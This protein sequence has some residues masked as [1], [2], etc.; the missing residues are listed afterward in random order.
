MTVIAQADH[1][2][3]GAWVACASGVFIALGNAYKWMH[4]DL[5]QPKNSHGRKKYMKLFLSTFSKV[6]AFVVFSQKWSL[7]RTMCLQNIKVSKLN[8]ISPV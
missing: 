5:K 1:L 8:G 4:P 3:Y 2:T 6:C 7:L